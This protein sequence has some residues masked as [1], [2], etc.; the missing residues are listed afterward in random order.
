[1]T[2][3]TARRI[4]GVEVGADERSIKSAYRKAASRV[5]PDVNPSDDAKAEFQELTEAYNTLLMPS[6]QPV[7]PPI[8][9]PS[10][11]RPKAKRKPGPTEPFPT[12]RRPL[13]DKTSP[14]Y[15]KYRSIAAAFFGES[16]VENVEGIVTDSEGAVEQGIK[17]AFDLLGVEF[18]FGKRK[19]K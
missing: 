3:N 10:T 7:S 14:D 12:H 1:M 6:P 11:S 8:P 16:A 15:K 5:H 13:V 4:L 18:D 19:P 17:S 9:E 2:P